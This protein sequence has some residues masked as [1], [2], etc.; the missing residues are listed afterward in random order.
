VTDH[1]MRVR[2]CGETDPGA[3]EGLGP[4]ARIRSAISDPKALRDSIEDVLRWP[5]ERAIVAHGEIVES[6]CH[7]RFR[8]GFAFLT[9]R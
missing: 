6:D 7:A 1:G 4:H 9:R 2:R 8:E 3:A 5:F